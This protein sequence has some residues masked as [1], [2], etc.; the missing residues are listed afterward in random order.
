MSTAVV[1][2]PQSWTEQPYTDEHLQLNGKTDSDAARSERATGMAEMAG[3]WGFALPSVSL[4][5]GLHRPPSFP[6]LHL[7]NLFLLQSFLLGLLPRFL[8]LTF[9]TTYRSP[10]HDVS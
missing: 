3:H 9:R 4:C 7:R 6:P 8:I 2:Y 10:P 1:V 5:V